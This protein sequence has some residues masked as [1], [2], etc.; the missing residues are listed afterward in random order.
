MSEELYIKKR[1][2]SDAEIEE[3]GAQAA[4]KRGEK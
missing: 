1:D 2:L 3:L 4:E